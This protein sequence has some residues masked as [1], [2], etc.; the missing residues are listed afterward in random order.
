[1]DALAFRSTAALAEAIRQRE[2]GS[3]E[4]LD[5][6]ARRIAE[7]NDALNAVVTLDLEA[8]REE[9]RRADEATARGEVWGPLHGVPFTIKDSFETAG[10]R[11]TCGHP[12]LADHVPSEDA[13]AVA[14]L[15]MAGAVVFGK[16]NLPALA[17][18]VQTYNPIFGTTRNPWDPTRT[19]GGSS[20]GAAAALAAGLT[21]GELGSDIGGSIRTP[22]NWCGVYGHKPSYG[23]VPQRGHIPGPPGTL[24]ESD[25]EVIGPL[26]RSAEDLALGLDVL[27]GPS[28]EEGV[29]W[30]LDLPGPRCDALRSYRVAAWLDDP[31]FPVDAAV[32]G[33]H[34]E[35]VAALRAAGVAVHEE[36]RPEL[37]LAEL[38]DTYMELLIPVVLAGLPPEQERQ[39]AETAASVAPEKAGPLARTV[40]N[41]ALSHRA[42]LAADERRAR[43]RAAFR[44]FFR[45]FD[46]LLMPV[47][48]VVAIPHDSEKPIP[49]RTIEV[50]GRE[51]PYESLFGWIAPATMAYLPATVAPVG[52]T[53]AGLPVGIQIVGPYLEDR[54]TIHFAGELG[55]VVGGFA[56]PPEP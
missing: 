21:G 41:L 48:P 30:T 31:A 10:L 17:A 39:L 37:A 2:V 4:V 44:T 40:R 16:T 27:A 55:T 53:P 24:A 32:R 19:P 35:T 3:V 12:P 9:A 6:Y 56:P 14:R 8:A 26:G 49:L 33:V 45:D 29:A 25:L 28:A 46:V 15:R 36:A 38:V 7:R 47:T 50:N 1:V 18:D 52:R 20:G 23:L 43:M 42:W 5:H 34:A 22:A 11:T 51:R 54:T 13:I